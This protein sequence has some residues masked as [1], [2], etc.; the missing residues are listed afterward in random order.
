MKLT[1]RAIT[2]LKN[3]SSI[4]PSIVIKPGN[5]IRTVSKL[6]SVLAEAKIDC[7]FPKQFAI[8][9]L[10]RF[11]SVLALHEEP[12]LFFEDNYVLIKSANSTTKYFY[13][14][15]DI[16][17]TNDKNI[18]LPSSEVQ[19]TVSAAQL[20]QLNKAMSTLS[21]T[22]MA[23]VGDGK[24]IQLIATDMQGRVED[25]YSIEIGQTDKIFKHYFS[26]DN[27]KLIPAVY[28]VTISYNANKTRAIAYFKGENIEYW[29]VAQAQT[30]KSEG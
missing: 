12:E 19:F 3:F 13:C 17:V 18:N 15:P 9:D 23:I 8:Y 1:P 24:T 7:E 4:N 27:L 16:V 6:T 5:N 22:E 14:S 2:I 21:V 11:I 25:Q 26:S 29:V 28:N 20:S 30:N 10:S